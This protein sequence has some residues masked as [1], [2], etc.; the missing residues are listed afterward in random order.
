M[1]QEMDFKGTAQAG[2]GSRPY[3]RQGQGVDTEVR[4]LLLLSANNKVSL[5]Q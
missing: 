2:M 1:P 5:R 4:Q 3:Y